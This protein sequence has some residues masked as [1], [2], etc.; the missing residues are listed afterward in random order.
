MQSFKITVR[1]LT[2]VR[3]EAVGLR[4]VSRVG[5]LVNPACC[6]PLKIYHRTFWR[7]LVLKRS[8]PHYN[9]ATEQQPRADIATPDIRLAHWKPSQCVKEE[10]HR[11]EDYSRN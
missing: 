9:C 10:E 7:S 4:R 8:P 3:L 5:D 11:S 1:Y 2:A 6:E